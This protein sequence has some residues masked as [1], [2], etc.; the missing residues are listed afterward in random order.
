MMLYFFTTPVACEH[1][2]ELNRK[3]GSANGQNWRGSC[4]GVKPR[5]ATFVTKFLSALKTML[6]DFSSQHFF[7]SIFTNLY[8]SVLSFLS[9]VKPR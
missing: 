9:G 8:K 1:N 6:S 3:N 7:V 4:G 2:N 5:R